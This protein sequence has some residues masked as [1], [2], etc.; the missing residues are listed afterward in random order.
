MRKGG[1][2]GKKKRKGER[3]V[4]ERFF[5]MKFSSVNSLSL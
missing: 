2:E 1:R 3:D 5:L 4:S